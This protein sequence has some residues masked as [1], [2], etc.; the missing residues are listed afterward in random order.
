MGGPEIQVYPGLNGH[1]S[2]RGQGAPDRNG[3][4]VSR[5]G[6]TAVLW[7]CFQGEKQI[8]PKTNGEQMVSPDGYALRR[9]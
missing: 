3:F 4:S 7:R 5:M 1:G 6:E 2:M 8:S 9:L